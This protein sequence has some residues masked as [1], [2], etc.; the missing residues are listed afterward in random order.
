[1]RMQDFYKTISP[2]EL[3]KY[4]EKVGLGGEF[5]VDLKEIENVLQ[6][7]KVHRVLEVGC[8]IGRLG[9]HLIT[10]YDYTGIDFNKP[11][12]DSFRE[13]LKKKNIPFLEG[14]LLNVSF[15]DYAGKDFD[16]VLFPW[17][18]IDDFSK[19]DQER[20]LIKSKN[21]LSSEGIIIIDHP[22]KGEILNSASGYEPTYFFF[23]DWKNDFPKLG[24]SHVEQALYTTAIRRQEITILHSS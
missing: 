4:A 15:F 9:V 5:P 20:T 21:M 13:K 14:Q 6:K 7:N 16:A 10:K 24:F 17:S 12:L 11:Y 19:N 23:E 22:Q 1:M 2:K 3:E 8:G 18:V